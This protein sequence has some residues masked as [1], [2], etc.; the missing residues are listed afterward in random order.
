[1]LPSATS[2]T[3]NAHARVYAGLKAALMEGDFVPGERLVV[4]IIAERFQT[5]PM[6]VREALQRLVS[7]EA[8]VE[9]ANR[10]AIVPEVDSEKISDLVRVRLPI[11]GTA[12]EWAA[13]TITA[14]E[15]QHLEDIDARLHRCAETDDNSDFLSLNRAFHF[16]IYRAARSQLMLPII[17]R[18]WL[19]AGPWLN[20]VRAGAMIGLD[21]DHHAEMLDALRRG[22]GA[23]ARRALVADISDAADIMLRSLNAPAVPTAL[24]LAS[25]GP[26]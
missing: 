19:R 17:E 6:P 22:A 26:T 14:A 23:R 20:L 24:H 13:A 18:L 8:L 3:P 10:G 5:S 2:P 12:T 7:E 21:L 15:L 11:E 16:T 9:H 1:M 4:R 25:T